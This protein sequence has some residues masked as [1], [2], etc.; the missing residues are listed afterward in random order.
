MNEAIASIRERHSTDASFLA[1]PANHR[2]L[3]Q[4]VLEVSSSSYY[5]SKWC[6][7]LEPDSHAL[8]SKPSRAVDSSA[9][10]LVSELQSGVSRMQLHAS[11]LCLMLQQLVPRHTSASRCGTVGASS[12]SA[13]QVARQRGL[14]TLE[15]LGVPAH[16]EHL[17][18]DTQ[19]LACAQSEGQHRRPWSAPMGTR[20]Q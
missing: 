14:S 5:F 10:D 6:H 18:S 15:L 20:S 9:D 2:A 13:W 3:A 7:E 12:P 1:I 19:H 11:K 8:I 16:M 4:I 17:L